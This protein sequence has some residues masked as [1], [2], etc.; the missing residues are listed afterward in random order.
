MPYIVSDYIEGLTL[1]DL[2]SGARP[3]PRESAEMV[4]QIADS[5]AYAHQAGVIHRDIKPSNI[6][7]DPAG[8]LHLTDFGLARR[9]EGEA[10]V[11][12]DGQILGTPAYMSPEQAAGDQRTVGPRSDLYGLGVVLYVL[13]TGELPFR[14]S[15][16]MLIHQVLHDDPKP[17]RSLDDKVPRDLETICLKSMAKEPSKRYGSAQ[18]FAGDLRRFLSGEPIRARRVGTVER[19]WRWSRRKPATAG[20]VAAIVALL[21]V[22]AVGGTW[23][24]FRE[25]VAGKREHELRTQVQGARPEHCATGPALPR[26]GRALMDEGDLSGSLVWFAEA[27]QLD[28]NDR[29]RRE[30][31]PHP[32]HGDS[33]ALPSTCADL[34]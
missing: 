23:F 33:A 9:D 32:P 13:L 4:A 34:G 30:G 2:L 20:L 29:E 11:T 25:R 15:S 18:E 14:G 26:R 10:V 31:P 21:L 7:L 17:P 24:A 16:R 27:L 28:Q 22:T 8:R 5:L 19:T 6:L 3:G 12:L 1:A